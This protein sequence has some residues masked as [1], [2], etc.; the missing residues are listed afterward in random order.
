MKKITILLLLLLPF[1]M[2]CSTADS[3]TTDSVKIKK[4]AL[5]ITY[6]PDLCYRN[7]NSAAEHKWISDIR[8]TLETGKMGHTTGVNLTININK[9]ISLSTGILFSDKGAKTKRYTFENTGNLNAPAFNTITFHYYYI[10]IPLKVNYYLHD[11]KCKFYIT[12]GMSTNI[13]IS[14]KNTSKIEYYNKDSEK[15]T[16]TNKQPDFAKI[17]FAVIAGLGIDCPITPKYYFK[18]EPQFRYSINSI[19]KAPIKEYLYSAGLN[20]GIYYKF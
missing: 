16:S 15:I 13:F 14:Q 8:D 11:K 3:T 2:Y 1:R 6:S 4:Y 20:I 10:D 9:K 17:N 19:I 12:G 18:L 7:L 5:G